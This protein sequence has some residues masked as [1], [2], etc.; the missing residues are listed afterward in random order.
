MRK[1]HPVEIYRDSLG[2]HDPNEIP[3][4]SFRLQVIV[5]IA[6]HVQH[7]IL[8]FLQKLMQRG[9]LSKTFRKKAYI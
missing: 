7:D 5:V 1:C 2:Y 3:E 9:H 4:H 6:K 8:N